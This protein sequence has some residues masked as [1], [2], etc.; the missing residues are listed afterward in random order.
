MLTRLELRTV[1]TMSTPREPL[2]LDEDE[3]Y[4]PGSRNRGNWSNGAALGAR[5]LSSL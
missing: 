2:R 5:T 3:D 1:S 4:V